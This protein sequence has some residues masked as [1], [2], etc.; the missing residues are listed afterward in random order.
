MINIMFIVGVLVFK[1]LI[2]PRAKPTA[3]QS[4]R[5]SDKRKDGGVDIETKPNKLYALTGDTV[6]TKTNK[7]Y[8]V[9]FQ[10]EQ[11]QPVTY[12]YVDP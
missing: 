10:M 8:G 2:K 6:V 3:K 9:S 5:F 1:L 7:V 11:S 4:P 12:D